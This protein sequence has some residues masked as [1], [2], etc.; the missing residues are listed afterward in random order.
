LDLDGEK[1][2]FIAAPPFTGVL[3]Y[4]ETLLPPDVT[5]VCR[6]PRR[7]C[8]TALNVRALANTLPPPISSIFEFCRG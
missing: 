7:V 3:K 8:A 6:D 2:G 5:T 4:A 1:I